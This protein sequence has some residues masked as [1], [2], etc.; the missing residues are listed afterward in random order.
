MQPHPVKIEGLM[1]RASSIIKKHNINFKKLIINGISVTV[2]SVY[3][4]F[5]LTVEENI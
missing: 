4:K 1:S 2:R 3:V 5:S